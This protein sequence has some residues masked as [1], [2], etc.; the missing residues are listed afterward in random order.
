MAVDIGPK[1]GIDGEKEFRQQLNDIN[2]TLKTLG[3][4]MKKVSSEFQENGNS[5]EALRK[6]NEVLNK[7]IDEQKKKL[8]M[9]Q[10]ALEESRDKFGETS[11]KTQQWQQVLN[12]TETAL[13]NLETELN[14][15]EKALQEMDE[16]LRDVETGLKKVDDSA[17]GIKDIKQDF[18]DAAENGVMVLSG[19]LVG[20][21]AAFAG[22]AE[23]SREYRTDQAKLQ[24][25]F[26]DAG[27]S[28]EQAK[29]A[30]TE[31]YGLLGED[32]TS[33]E[34][35]NHLAELTDNEKE[36]ATWTGDILPGVFAKFGDSL[37]LEGL[38]EAANETAKVGTVT[39]SL[40]DALNWAGISEDEFNEQLAK[41]SDEQ[42]RQQLITQTLAD[43]YGSA[44]T[45]FKETN[46][47]VIEANKAQ[48]EL[49]DA[50]A[51]LGAAAEPVITKLKDIL[52]EVI[53]T[54]TDVVEKFNELPEST[55]N[56]IL[57]IGG[58][59]IAAGPTI[60]GISSVKSGISALAKGFKSFFSPAKAAA[61]AV[62]TVGTAATT[63]AGSTGVL[64]G[65]VS[66]L[67]GLI[68]A[69]P[70]G[71]LVTALGL[72]ATGFGIAA[73][74]ASYAE[75][76]EGKFQQ[77]VKESREEVEQYRETMED[78][79]ETREN[80]LAE[81]ESEMSYYENLKTELDN[82]VDANGKVK[83]GYEA[84][85]QFITE[86]LS[87]ALGT[88][89]EMTD[90]VIKNYDQLT[91]SIDQVIEKKR[92]EA[93][94]SAYE[95]EYT[96]ALKNQQEAVEN[97][98]VAKMELE[99]AEEAYDEALKHGSN[100]SL[101]TA[102]ERLGNART[103]M[104]EATTAYKE[105]GNAIMQY[106]EMMTAF[107]EGNY[108]RMY[109]IA[110]TGETDIT[111]LT[112]EQARERLKTVENEKATYLALYEETGDE[113]F[114][115]M[116]NA[117]QKEIDQLK[118]HLG[119]M[120]G[121]IGSDTSFSDAMAKLASEGGGAFLQYNFKQLGYDVSSGVAQGIAE[122]T[123]SLYKTVQ[124]MAGKIGEW[125]SNALEINSPSK[126][127]MRL[128][129]SVPE[130]VAEGMIK[131]LP[132]IQRAGNEMTNAIKNIKMPHDISV[133]PIQSAPAMSQPQTPINVTV[134]SVLDGKIV[135][136]SVQKDITQAQA[137]NMRMKGVLI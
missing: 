57:A 87:G 121:I 10:K 104:D 129:E 94:L 96:E 81:S 50:I 51:D 65:A 73:A 98:T 13:N 88:E 133:Q 128:S 83:K 54:I 23:S 49:T 42:E 106:E 72:L 26:E 86:T 9:V 114:K 25:A 44:S 43:T 46:A 47:Q 11:T 48:A 107:Q 134:Y 53:K 82:L 61:T 35:A 24:V 38:T 112:R 45:A 2:T 21:A 33:V 14:Q 41:C 97:L 16:G 60:K 64:S 52:T 117:Q 93:A 4:E 20:L 125:F 19:A 101:A 124:N 68:A 130:G 55:Q 80:T 32:D 39:G 113:T 75:T 5:Q 115:T 116:A 3:T 109:E 22:A 12:R 135:S 17:E 84:R 56:A 58:I 132:Y 95:A 79:A 90:G 74:Q 126:V 36:L 1:I 137:A 111:N 99:A 28:A 63:A 120:S 108:E 34:A 103:A 69:H 119:D 78:L 102:A 77:R 7:T 66:S 15:N 123:S 31:I 6:K 29:T 71:A 105:N 85:A 89:I 30:F 76:E 118:R 100:T 136:K 8:E 27:Y 127:M 37:P 62:G 110:Y 91:D 59:G 70:I 122:K 40:A 92:A 18:K 131:G 67:F